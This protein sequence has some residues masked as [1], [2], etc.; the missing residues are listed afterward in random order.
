MWEKEKMMIPAVSPFTP[1]V[2]KSSLIQDLLKELRQQSEKIILLPA[3]IIQV[4]CPSITYPSLKLI[5]F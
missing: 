5:L 2:F 4:P 3:P 1:N